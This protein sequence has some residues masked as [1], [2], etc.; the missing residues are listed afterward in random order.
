MRRNHLRPAVIVLSVIAAIAW[1]IV[2]TAADVEPLPPPVEA[3]TPPTDTPGASA[4]VAVSPEASP[5][6]S[7][8]GSDPSVAP[9]PDGIDVTYEDSRKITWYKPKFD[10]WRMFDFRIYP[11]IARDDGG[12]RKIVLSIVV[13][14]PY[15]G[16]PTS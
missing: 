14:D 13:K 6:P 15:K 12:A 10:P 8:T 11:S 9:A 2:A 3:P 5:S 16:R 1:A 4:A 7:A